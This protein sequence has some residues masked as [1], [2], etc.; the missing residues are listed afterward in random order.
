MKFK[1]EKYRVKDLEE[2]N[3]LLIL[4]FEDF[5][6]AGKEAASWFRKQFHNMELYDPYC[7]YEGIQGLNSVMRDCD[8][9]IADM[10]Q[11]TYLYVRK[12]ELFSI[13]R[14]PAGYP[15]VNIKKADDAELLPN[16]D[17]AVRIFESILD[18]KTNWDN[19]D[20]S[21]NVVEH[22]VG[23][24]GVVFI[25]TVSLY[26]AGLLPKQAAYLLPKTIRETLELDPDS[27]AGIRPRLEFEDAF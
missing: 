4:L 3:S 1:D 18:V 12:S 2:V 22:Y 11:L 15:A 14:P 17:W 8:D 27:K 20:R 7:S 23:N 9:L 10:H 6:D 19:S 16:H 24:E 13:F 5:G 21:Y 26:G 25:D